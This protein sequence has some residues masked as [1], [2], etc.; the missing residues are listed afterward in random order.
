MK[1]NRTFREGVNIRLPDGMRDEIQRRAKENRRSMNAEIVVYLEQVI[2]SEY[3]NGTTETA[4]SSCH[5][6]QIPA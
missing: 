3:N 2:G 6:S 4:I 1:Q 5:G